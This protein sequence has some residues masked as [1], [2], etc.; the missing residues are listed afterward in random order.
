M[1][2]KDC[3]HLQF[4]NKIYFEFWSKKKIFLFK[5]QTFKK[6]VG[7]I[8]TQWKSASSKPWG[9][10]FSRQTFTLWSSR[11]SHCKGSHG[12][13]IL[14]WV[15][16]SFDGFIM[17]RVINKRFSIAHK[18]INTLGIKKLNPNIME[19]K[20]SLI[21]FKSVLWGCFKQHFPN[22][23]IILHFG[24]K[25]VGQMYMHKSSVILNYNE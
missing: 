2:E 10:R 1:K 18:Q 9:L 5:F 23:L 19:T 22:C 3:L 13:C 14:L 12:S 8:C 6:T 15:A 24:E 17:F 11:T 20:L 4:L 7:K 21:W 16:S 25:N